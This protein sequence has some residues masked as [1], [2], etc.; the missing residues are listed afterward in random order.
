[1]NYP[2]P[3]RS[4]SIGRWPFRIMKEKF[5]LR[6]ALYLMLAPLLNAYAAR[7]PR[8]FVQGTV[9]EVQE[10][11]VQSPSYMMGGSNPADTPL[12]ARYYTYE[13][14]IRAGCEIY[15]GR[16][17]TV[18]NYLPSAFTAGR[19]ISLR[20]TKH[21]MYFDLPNDPDFRMGIVRHRRVCG[22][23]ADLCDD[24]AADLRT[25]AWSGRSENT[26]STTRT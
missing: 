2:H 22:S 1:M 11:R 12:T 5:S 4:G 21:V 18:L 13:V 17:Q 8:Q 20:L 24:S 16:Y 9:V 3:A 26:I 7:V 14:S 23:T 10:Q 25:A 15:V 6:I 19:P